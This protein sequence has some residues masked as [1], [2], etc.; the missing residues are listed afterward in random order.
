MMTCIDANVHLLPIFKE[1]FYKKT[2]TKAIFFIFCLLFCHLYSV[3][4][5][6]GFHTVTT[7]F[8]YYIRV[9]LFNNENM[10]RQILQQQTDTVSV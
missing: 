4:V 3:R 2:N 6:P 10:R 9:F 7:F 8:Y 5:S 1:T